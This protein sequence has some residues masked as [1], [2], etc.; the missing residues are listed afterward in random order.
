MFI[1]VL[2]AK[3]SKKILY[4]ISK[5][6]PVQFS[7]SFRVE[8]VACELFPNLF[9][10]KFSRKKLNVKQKRQLNRILFTESVW[11]IDQASM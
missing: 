3:K 10:Q 4:S 9:S 8:V 11:K 7:G 6:I 1:F 2:D 5:R